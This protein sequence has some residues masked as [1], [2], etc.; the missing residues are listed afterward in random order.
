MK[1]QVPEGT[2]VI[3]RLRRGFG[4]AAQVAAGL[5]AA[6][7]MQQLRGSRGRGA[8]DVER[9]VAPVGGHL[10][11]AAG[12]VGRGAHRLQHHLSGCNAQRQAQGAIAIVGEK[13]VVSG[14]HRQGRANLQR[15]V[16]RSR[17]LEEDLLLAFEQDFAVIHAAGKHHQP[18]EFHD[19]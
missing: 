2:V 7:R 6:D 9:A 16:A 5:G 1:F 4:M 10:P 13:P 11:A 8:D 3:W 14:T 12:G 18:V 17:N 19:P 15:L